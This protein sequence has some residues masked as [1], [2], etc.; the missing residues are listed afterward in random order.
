VAGVG[1][2]GVCKQTP[3]GCW[4]MNNA[5]GPCPV[6]PGCGG[7]FYDP[8]TD[9]LNGGQHM[10]CE[11]GCATDADCPAPATGTAHATC[12]P[13]TKKCA[14]ECAGGET[15]PDGFVCIQSALTFVTDG[16]ISRPPRQCVQYKE[17]YG[18][19]AN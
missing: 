11:Y 16:T 19:P 17:V 1:Y 7:F 10:V 2:G 13:Y 4:L 3:D 18:L 15:C 9:T 8:A 12:S 14:L 5:A 6:S